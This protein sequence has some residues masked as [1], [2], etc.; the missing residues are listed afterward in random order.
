MMAQGKDSRALKQLKIAVVGAKNAKVLQQ[1]GLSP[2]F[3][4]PDFV[5]DSL[6]S[7]FPEAGGRIATNFISPRGQRGST[8]C[9]CKE[10]TAAG[11]EVVEVPAYESGCPLV[12]DEAAIAAHPGRP[13][14]CDHL[15]QFE[16]RGPHLP[17]AGPGGRRNLARVIGECRR[18]LD[19]PQNFRYLPGESWAESNIEAAEYTL[20]GLTQ[21]IATWANSASSD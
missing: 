14:R 9:W 8:K 11:A 10:F 7:H 5:A 17:A 13:G 16:N 15:C 18:C 21:A 2:D 3:V 6:V 1:W 20:E 19:W 4:P 12:A